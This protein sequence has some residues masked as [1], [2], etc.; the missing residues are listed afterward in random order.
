MFF[1]K[2]PDLQA[3]LAP[4][5]CSQAWQRQPQSMI[6]YSFEQAA[7]GPMWTT[8]D[9][10]LY[11]LQTT[12]EQCPKGNLIRQALNSSE[13]NSALFFFIIFMRFYFSYFLNFFFFYFFSVFLVYLILLFIFLKYIVLIMLL[14]FSQFPPLFSPSTLYLQPSSIP[15]LSSCPWVVHISSLSPL[16]PIP[17]FISPHLPYA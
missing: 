12:E 13:M 5:M 1:F 11:K 8:S 4:P 3:N 10:G 7:E 15:P 6:A 16:F 9:I 14:Q 17:F 2:K